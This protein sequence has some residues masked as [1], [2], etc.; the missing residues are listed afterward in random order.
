MKRRFILTSVIA[1]LV[2]LFA[3]AA[4][5]GTPQ[6]IIIGLDADM[7]SG[8]AR[9]GLAIQRGAE[10]AIQE[11][12]AEGGVLGRSMQLVVKDHRGNPARGADNIKTFSAMD[13]VVAVLGTLHTPVAL[14]ELKLIHKHQMIYLSPWAAGTPIVANGYNPNFVFRISVRDEYAGGFLVGE[15]LKKGYH[16]VALAL[17]NTGWGRSN[18]R[19]MKAALQAKGIAPVAVA[20]FHWGAKNMEQA[21]Q[22]FDHKTVDAILLVA[23]APEGMA[24]VKSMAVRPK[25]A[26]VPI[27]SHWGITGGRFF[28]QAKHLL[29]KVDLSFLQTYSFTHPTMPER[30]ESVIKA[31]VSRYPD[32]DDASAIFA[33]AGTA[34]AYDLVHLLVK[35]IEKAGST[36]RGKVRAALENLDHH[37]GLVR[38]YAPAFTPRKHDALDI[39]DFMLSTY[40]RHG[41]IVPAK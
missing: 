41:H 40:D 16:R 11:I 15:A 23:N 26:R 21:I 33:P 12:N 37:E 5:A 9:S 1:A 31:Y 22:S 18:E 20:W 3:P 4:K 38:D 27:I 2:V 32:A 28:E 29:D 35:A 13:G 30:A 17:E 24:I 36:D 7:S 10:I 14:H 19:A 6:P 8:S 39:S 34:H 25:E